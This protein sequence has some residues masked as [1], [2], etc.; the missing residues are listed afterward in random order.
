MIVAIIGF[1]SL[2]WE[3]LQGII[4][5]VL[6]VLAA[7]LFLAGG[8]AV[9]V[10]LR[11]VSCSNDFD[12]FNNGLLNGGC[13]KVQGETICFH[14]DTSRRNRCHMDEADSAFMFMGFIVCAGLVAHTF[15]FGGR[16][17]GRKSMV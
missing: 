4:M 8:I 1:I 17:A 7:L 15:W 2:F 12:T 5:L 13:T 6:D 10:G 3:F 11:G 14:N 16:M 9:A